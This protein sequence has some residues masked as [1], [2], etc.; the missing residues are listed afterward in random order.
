MLLTRKISLQCAHCT[1]FV[2]G[3]LTVALAINPGAPRVMILLLQKN[4]NI[5]N[6]AIFRY[7]VYL[8]IYI[9]V[10]QRCFKN[11]SKQFH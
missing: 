5:M 4:T 9:H 1:R 7:S 10:S 11:E 3:A 6:D 2:F 8:F